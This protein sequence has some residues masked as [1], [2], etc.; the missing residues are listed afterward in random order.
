MS[1]KSDNL[2]KKGNDIG[3]ITQTCI[4]NKNLY[5][6][7]YIAGSSKCTNKHIHKF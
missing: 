6:K 3:H 1:F 4:L 2:H 7:K 5:R